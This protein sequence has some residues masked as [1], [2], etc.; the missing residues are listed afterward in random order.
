MRNESSIDAQLGGPGSRIL[1]NSDTPAPRHPDTLLVPLAAFLPRSLAN[2]P[3]IR[4]V[5][6]VQGCPFRCP[7]CFNPDFLEFTG[8]Q[9]TPVETLVTWI[10]ARDDTEGLTFS[11]GEPFAHAPVLAIVAEQVQR[12]GKSVLI[13]TGYQKNELLGS[14]D[15]GTRRLLQSA[16]LLIAGPYRREQ[17]SRHP[18]LGS[19]NQELVFLTERY[20]RE[21]AEK[22]RKRIEFRI[23]S[24][25]TTS[26]TGFPRGD[27]ANT[28]SAP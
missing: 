11:G 18:W 2:G 27:D 23:A 1:R 16:D 8:G 3:G 24:D 6:W 14:P 10:L 13:F 9:P 22:G 20:R 21:V 28:I 15:P 4:S 26:V 25:G 7:G 12:E 17:P 5:L 19:T